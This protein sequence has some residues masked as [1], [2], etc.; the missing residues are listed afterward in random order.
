MSLK[1][2]WPTFLYAFGIVFQLL[3]KVCGEESG[4]K[5]GKVLIFT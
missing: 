3:D 5:K 2:I 1:L 4:Y